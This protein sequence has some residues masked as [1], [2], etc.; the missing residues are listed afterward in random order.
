MKEIQLTRGYKTQ[1]DDVDYE[2][3][4][5]NFK[6]FQYV[7]VVRNKYGYANTTKKIG[8]RV[9]HIKVAYLVMERYTIMD[10]NREIDHIDRNPLNNQ[11][12]NLRLVTHKENMA[13][14][15]RPPKKI[16]CNK[17]NTNLRLKY[18]T[19]CSDCWAEYQRERRK[20]AG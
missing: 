10:I 12:N 17:C 20:K 14:I 8:A 11:R 7:E 3:L 4:T 1:V 16:I 18:I 6:K 9:R 13:N 2:Y 15:D 5:T 19:Y